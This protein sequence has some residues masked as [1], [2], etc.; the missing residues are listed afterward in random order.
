MQTGI[1]STGW[2]RRYTIISI[3]L[4]F[5]GF[6]FQ[7]I[8]AFFPLTVFIQ[9]TPDDAYYL[10][11]TADN[12][13]LGKGLSFDGVKP[14]TSARPLYIL[15]LAGLRYIVVK[16][17]LPLLAFILG[18][19]ANVFTAFLILRFL[20]KQKL[21]PLISLI[22]MALYL[23]SSREFNFTDNGMETPFAVF[24]LVLVINLYPKEGEGSRARVALAVGRG[25]VT[26]F[27][28]LLRLDYCFFAVPIMLWELIRSYK[29]RNWDFLW[30][31][32]TVA[33]CMLPWAWWS[34]AERGGLM[35][36][37]GDALAMVLWNKPGTDIRGFVLRYEYLVS[38]ISDCFPLIT[39]FP[40]NAFW[41]VLQYLLLVWC[42]VTSYRSGISIFSPLKRFWVICFFA[43]ATCGL[44]GFVL[45]RINYLWYLF[46]C[47]PMLF[48]FVMIL[49]KGRFFKGILFKLTPVWVGILALAFYFSEIRFFWRQWNLVVGDLIL[50]ILLGAFLADIWAGGRRRITVLFL[51]LWILAINVNDLFG[52]TWPMGI[53]NPMPAKYYELAY[54][55]KTNTNPDTIIASANG[56][57]LAWFS[58]RELVDTAGI[59]DIDSYNALKDSRLYDYI[60]QRKVKYLVDMP[61]WVFH[62]YRDRWGVDIQSKIEIY[63]DPFSSD[64]N[65]LISDPVIFKIL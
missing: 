42:I 5:L 65:E 55:L 37:S 61:R 24:T 34:I 9:H 63:Y 38:T 54:W 10:Y 31:G 19:L 58:E 48:L 39:P 18:V 57:V 26:A 27:M 43:I 33:V 4:L 20:R 1:K 28:M 21:P 6:S 56:G 14:T 49:R 17:Y 41:I 64:P 59:E 7:I 30:A 15:M 13:V 47:L 52:G 53:T 2:T 44:T 32:F 62:N 29:R 22:A 40:V 16:D 36:P 3:V 35:P 11:K 60:K 46:Y 8:P 23:F 50:Y 12:L 25:I 51:S 45:T